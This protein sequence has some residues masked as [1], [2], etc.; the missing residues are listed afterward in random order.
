[1]IS[2]WLNLQISY[3]IIFTLLRGGFGASF[4]S[5]LRPRREVLS[6]NWDRIGRVTPK[7]LISDHALSIQEAWPG[8]EQGWESLR[9]PRSK[10]RKAGA[11]RYGAQ[12]RSRWVAQTAYT[13]LRYISKRQRLLMLRGNGWHAPFG[14]SPPSW[15]GDDFLNGVV[16]G[17]ARAL[18]R[19]ENSVDLRVIASVSEAIQMACTRIRIASSLSLLAMTGP[20]PPPRSET[21]RGRGTMRSMVEGASGD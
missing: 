14:A 6:L 8:V 19:R 17:K 20:Y 21:K 4:P 7:G 5:V 10:R 11:P 18:S 15:G 3:Q 2:H 9:E 13:R 12:P 16:V 1:M